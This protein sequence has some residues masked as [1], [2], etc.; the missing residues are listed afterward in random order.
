MGFDGIYSA[1]NSCSFTEMN[2]KPSWVIYSTNIKQVFLL[3]LVGYCNKL[4]AHQFTM[5]KKANVYDCC[6][7]EVNDM[8]RV[9]IE[10][11]KLK[12]QC[13]GGLTDSIGEQYNCNWPGHSSLV[14][15]PDR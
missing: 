2:L 10:N 1:I 8:M 9:R 14:V 15:I 7:Q 12:L 6:E 13:N 11:N 3:T 4:F 5:A